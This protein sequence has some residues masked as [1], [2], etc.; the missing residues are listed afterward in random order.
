MVDPG[1]KLLPACGINPEKQA[2]QILVSPMHNMTDYQFHNVQKSEHLSCF[3]PSARVGY[4]HPNRVIT[5]PY[6]VQSSLLLF[7][8]ALDGIEN[9]PYF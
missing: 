7:Q 3:L 6:L 9:I 8:N 2:L 5:Q 1:S 4:F